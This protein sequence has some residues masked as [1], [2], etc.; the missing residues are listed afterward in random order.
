MSGRLRAYLA[1][2]SRLP[3]T[4]TTTTFEIRLIKLYVRILRFLDQV[5]VT[6]QKGSVKRWW[7]VVWKDSEIDGFEQDCNTLTMQVA[8]DALP[9]EFRAAVLL[10]DVE[11]MDYLEIAETL[12]L[13][14]GTVRSRIHRGRQQMRKT[15]EQFGWKP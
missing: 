11:Q 10:C 1:Y 14:I 5:T 3:S 15:L 2:V 7:D 13:P 6:F 9:E 4:D 8:L 12:H